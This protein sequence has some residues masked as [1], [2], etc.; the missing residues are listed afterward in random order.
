MARVQGQ[1]P[2][3][4]PEAWLLTHAQR[5]VLRTETGLEV[6]VWPRT[7]HRHLTLF[8]SLGDHQH[9]GSGEEDRELHLCGLVDTTGNILDCQIQH[10]RFLLHPPN[11]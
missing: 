8:S 7:D 6:V 2:V 9:L 1:S 4:Q 5:A 10:R 11:F 3:G